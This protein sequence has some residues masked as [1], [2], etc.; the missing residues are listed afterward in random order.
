MNNFYD[1]A[2]E[3]KKALSKVYVSARNYFG[4]LSQK[5][6]KVIFQPSDPYND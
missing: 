6:Y 2:E 5:T 3:I 1:T 4:K